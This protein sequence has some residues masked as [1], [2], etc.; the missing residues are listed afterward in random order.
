MAHLGYVVGRLL[1][2]YDLE[3]DLLMEKN[4]PLNS[5]PLHFDPLLKNKYPDW[6]IFYD[7]KKSS[8][9]KDVLKI[10]R[11][12]KYDLIHSFV[13]L[14]IFAYISR[15]PF[16]VQA[17][18][19]DLRELAFTKSL[20]GILLRRAYKKSKI[21][22]TS[23]FNHLPLFPKLKI[24]NGIFLPFAWD[25]SF[26]KPIEF[27]DSLYSDKFLIFH[28]ANLEW[29]LKGNDILINGFAK[30][31]D[32]KSDSLLLIID[33]GVDSDSTHKL[34]KSLNIENNVKFIKGP[35]NSTELLR[36]YN[37][38]DVVADQFILQGLGNIGREALCCKKPLL[39]NCPNDYFGNYYPEGPPTVYASNPS[40]IAKQL[41]I[42]RDVEKRISVG[43]KGRGW[44]IKY[45]SEEK[46]FEKLMIIYESALKND[47]FEIIKQ[48]LK[49]I[50]E[51]IHSNS[52]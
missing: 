27:K 24:K 3:A 35:L 18:G 21:L 34:V 14:P 41:L 48:R 31:V 44:F 37:L 32:E 30:F 36:Y 19:S 26:F 45:H 11:N 29:R 1:R 4:P 2:K 28:P 42:L 17:Q 9:K 47:N 23:S 8:W 12:K 10:M 16:I 49:H 13:E 43:E 6:I 7:K 52:N 22:I 39:T 15:R 46:Y 38:A 25:Y 5:D 50:D 33:R 20:K 51:T 40:E